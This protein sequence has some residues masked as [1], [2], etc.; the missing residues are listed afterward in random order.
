MISKTQVYQTLDKYF[1]YTTFRDLQENIIMDVLV[2]RDVFTLMPTGSGK[3]LCYQ[4]PALLLNGV[5]IVVSPLISLMKDQVDG[6]VQNGIEAAF[7]NSTLDLSEQ[8]DIE[9]RL[10]KNK[11]K[12]LYLAPEKLV[13]DSFISFLKKI[14][15]SFFTIDE[16]HCISQWGHD[17]RPEY[18]KLNLLKDKFPNISIIALTATATERVSKD[19]VDQLKLNNAKIYSAS[20]D[21]TNLYYEIRAKQNAFDQLIQYLENHKNES[22]IIYCFSRKQVENLSKL[23]KQVGIKALPYHA[24]LE[25]NTRKLNQEKFIKDDVNIIVATTAFGMGINKPDVRFVIHY[26]LPQ[27][28]EQY[29]QETG[30]AGRDGLPSE[31]IL[32]F[33]Y[34]DKAKIEY[35]IF[36][37]PD[38]AEQEVAKYQLKQI[39]D[40]AETQVCRRHPLLKYF[41][42]TYSKEK[43][44]NCD[45]CSKPRSTFDATEV[46]QKVL[47]CVYRLNERFGINY[48]SKILKGGRFK[49]AS[50]PE[51][52]QLSTFGILKDLK[53]VTIAAYIRQTVQLGYLD[54]TKDQYPVVKLNE[55]SHGILKGNLK[56]FLNEIETLESTSRRKSSSFSAPGL[57][58]DDLFER[59]RIL[60]KSL[61]DKQNIPPYLVFSDATLRDMVEK[62]PKNDEEFMEVKGVGNQKLE[63]YGKAFINVIKDSADKDSTSG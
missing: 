38:P 40:F 35:F 11:I 50:D 23:L 58:S 3:S 59:L 29:Y 53:I 21:R 33:S 13:Q 52:L 63:R 42:E 43:C 20:F 61:S 26:D 41:G 44:L 10:L 17:F 34:G 46:V 25:S 9:D 22:G 6:L 1:G 62:R 49:A 31:C 55:K 56:V 4:L 2:G 14:Q 32:F 5:A 37:R 19:I 48:V 16:S 30:R 45:N 15:I 57:G 24:G 36:Q 39:L 54:T 8:R 60:R 7:L 18:R 51:H 27:S 12:I 28:L 47:S